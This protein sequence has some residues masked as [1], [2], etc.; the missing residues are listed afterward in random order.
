MNHREASPV[1]EIWKGQLIKQHLPK[2]MCP[3]YV[4]QRIQLNVFYAFLIEC[5]FCLAVLIS[6]TNSKVNKY[7]L[8]QEKDVFIIHPLILQL[9]SH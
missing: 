6:T 5:H 2:N 1:G 9:H 4:N 7:Y 3:K 8:S